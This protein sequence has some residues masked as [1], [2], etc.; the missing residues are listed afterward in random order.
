MNNNQETISCTKGCWLIAAG[1]GVLVALLLLVIG[2][3]SFLSSIFWGIVL[4]VIAGL[5]LN[6]IMCR[7]EASLSDSQGNGSSAAST[8]AQASSAQSGATAATEP[9]STT[10]TTAATTAT[11][12]AAASAATTSE[13]VASAPK[14][15][16]I[17]PSAP[18]AGQAELASRKGDW[19]YEGE[20]VKDAAD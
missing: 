16:E 18:L 7:P 14:A 20:V 9:A 12:T 13:K 19:K 2:G 10:A 17:K 5:L 1:A 11:A 15:V 3:W 6:W 8:S 4:F